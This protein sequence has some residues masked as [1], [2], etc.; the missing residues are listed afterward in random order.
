MRSRARVLKSRWTVGWGRWRYWV[1]CCN[2]RDDALE[3]ALDARR[4]LVGGGGLAALQHT[5]IRHE[6][7][8]AARS[9][10]A[11]HAS[12]DFASDDDLDGIFDAR[13]KWDG[14]RAHN[15]R[16]QRRRRRREERGRRHGGDGE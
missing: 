5:V 11:A 14:I 8:N 10:Q 3:N 12:G 2:L 6:P 1:V 16:R 15:S 7:H 9:P 4:R 13:E